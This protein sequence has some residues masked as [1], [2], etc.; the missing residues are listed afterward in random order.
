[1]PC[2]A[3]VYY[4]DMY[5]DAGLVARDRRAVRGLRTWVTNEYE[6]DGLRRDGEELLDHLIA[7]ARGER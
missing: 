2:A 3:A 1:M 6:H 4:D 7:L 5:V